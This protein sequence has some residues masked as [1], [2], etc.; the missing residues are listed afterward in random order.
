MQKYAERYISRHSRKTFGSRQD[1]RCGP[2]TLGTMQKS[3]GRYHNLTMY[4]MLCVAWYEPNHTIQTGSFCPYVGYRSERTE[5]FRIAQKR[6]KRR[7]SQKVAEWHFDR[8][9]PLNSTLGRVGPPAAGPLRVAP[10]RVARVRTTRKRSFLPIV[11]CAILASSA[12]RIR[13]FRHA[14]V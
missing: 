7:K 12:F 1:I 3:A 13:S 11:I 8:S 9:A 14:L 4:H 6:R 2:F 10:A 5:S